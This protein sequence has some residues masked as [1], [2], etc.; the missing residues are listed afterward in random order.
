MEYRIWFPCEAPNAAY[1]REVLEFGLAERFGGFTAIAAQGGWRDTKGETVTEPVTVYTAIRIGAPVVDGDGTDENFM[2]GLAEFVCER[3]EQE[4]V[5]WDRRENEA[6]MIT[7]MK[8][9]QSND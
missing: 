5:L 2:K 1:A 9:R 8:R 7:A 6:W 3:C 4:A